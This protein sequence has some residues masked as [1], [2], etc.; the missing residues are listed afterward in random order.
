MLPVQLSSTLREPL[1]EV[2]AVHCSDYRFIDGYHEFLSVNLGL[3]GNYDLLA[4]PGGPQ[5]LTLVEYKPE[6]SATSYTWSRFL[7]EAHALKRLILFQHQDC[8]WYRG[9]P[10]HYHASP[11]LRHRQE[12]DLRRVQ[13]TIGKE[14]PH[15]TVECYYVGW[16]PDR[17]IV[18]D[19]IDV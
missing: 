1:T 14:F 16:G 11:G 12:Q 8:A 6:H 7:V 5:S 10:L 15:L 9:I 17:H 3:K 13:S 19:R 2:L 18:V 4:I